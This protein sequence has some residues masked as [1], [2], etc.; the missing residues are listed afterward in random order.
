M[1]YQPQLL[2]DRN[3][4]PYVTEPGNSSTDWRYNKNTSYWVRVAVSHSMPEVG[5][6]TLGIARASD[7]CPD[8]KSPEDRAAQFVQLL[9]EKAQISAGTDV[10]VR[11]DMPDRWSNPHVN[12]TS[13]RTGA[14][15]WL[16]NKDAYAQDS[17]NWKMRTPKY[18]LQNAKKTLTLFFSASDDYEA[19]KQH[20]T[21]QI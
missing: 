15:V 5:E 14:A 17:V 18:N 19:Q 16:Q 8:S 12:E 20:S 21:L 9:L 1:S 6:K 10:V 11:L 2:D 7:I 13:G 3:H 4:N